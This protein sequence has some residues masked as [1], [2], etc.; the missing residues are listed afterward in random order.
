M[1]GR[2]LHCGP[3]GGHAE[4]ALDCAKGDRLDISKIRLGKGNSIRI[5]RLDFHRPEL[6]IRSVILASPGS[7]I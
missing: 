6:G 5:G 2:V 7:A 3:I 4:Y 1:V